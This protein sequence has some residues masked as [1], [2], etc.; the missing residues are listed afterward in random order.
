MIDGKTH[1]SFIVPMWPK[2]CVFKTG[3]GIVL[4]DSYELALNMTI[5]EDN[6][7]F[8]MHEFNII[9]DGRSA[10]LFGQ[11]TISAGSDELSPDDL[12]SSRRD[13]TVREVDL[14]TGKTLFQ[15]RSTEAMLD[16][17][18]DYPNPPEKEDWDYL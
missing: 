16:S 2:N 15:W 8:D 3:A 12:R 13:H 7:V 17:T 11:S 6:V 1:L 14:R 5:E 10:L 9:D 18:A 4:D